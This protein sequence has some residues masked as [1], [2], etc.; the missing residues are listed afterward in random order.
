M[1]AMHWEAAN[2]RYLGAALAW[3]RLRLQRL[4]QRPERH[5]EGAE[6][7]NRPISDSAPHAPPEDLTQ[8]PVVAAAQAMDEA[9][10]LEPPP[11]QRLLVLRP[12]APSGVE[13]N[14]AFWC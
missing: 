9:G 12:S 14:S 2:E 3:L 4:A 8:D 6:D 1:D 7:T 10:A 13:T 5:G 11:A